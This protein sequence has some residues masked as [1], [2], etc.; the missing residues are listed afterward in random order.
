MTLSTSAAQQRID[1]LITDHPLAQAIAYIKRMK[2]FLAASNSV[3]A[4][5]LSAEVTNFIAAYE[6]QK[7]Q[8]S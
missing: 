5:D 7:E 8:Q 3:R 2:P 6:R 4:M 1:A